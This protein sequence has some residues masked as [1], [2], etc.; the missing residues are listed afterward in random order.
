MFNLLCNFY[1]ITSNIQMSIEAAYPL[2]KA[3]CLQSLTNRSLKRDANLLETYKE[4]NTM[5]IKEN[6]GSK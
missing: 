2:A 4:K 5:E 6:H 3:A 1:K